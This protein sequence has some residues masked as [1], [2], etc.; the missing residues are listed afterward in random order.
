MKKLKEGDYVTVLGNAKGTVWESGIILDI[1]SE[2]AIIGYGSRNCPKWARLYG[3]NV[4]EPLY[5]L[6]LRKGSDKK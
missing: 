5:N 2:G 1:N 3:M 6:K 4:R